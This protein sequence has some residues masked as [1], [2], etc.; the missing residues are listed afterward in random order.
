MA[1]DYWRPTQGRLENDVGRSFNARFAS[2]RTTS[3][4]FGGEDSAE[5]SLWGA[6]LRS[7]ALADFQSINRAR[8]N[9]GRYILASALGV[10]QRSPDAGFRLLLRGRDG[11]GVAEAARGYIERGPIGSV[12]RVANE[13]A[14]IEWTPL[15]VVP[16]LKFLTSAAD[17]LDRDRLEPL[18]TRLCSNFDRLSRPTAL[19]R[20]ESTLLEAPSDAQTIAAQFALDLAM[21]SEDALTLQTLRRVIYAIDWSTQPVET[22]DQWV[23]FIRSALN[24]GGDVQMVAESAFF[25]L[26]P[27]RREDLAPL[28]KVERAGAMT[29][30]VSALQTSSP[31]DLTNEEAAAAAES[32]VGALE[33]IREAA[34]QGSFSF[35]RTYDA[36]ALLVTLLL[37][38]PELPYWDEV[39]SFVS[40]PNVQRADKLD[41][42]DLL[43]TNIESVPED[44][45]DALREGFDGV[46]SRNTS[47]FLP[48]PAPGFESILLRLGSALGTMTPSAVLQDLL[49]FASSANPALR[50]Q[51]A[52]AAAH[53]EFADDAAGLS[54]VLLLSRDPVPDVRAA[55]CRA[56]LS[57]RWGRPDDENALVW[58]RV[59]EL[60]SE[61]GR[62]PTLGVLLGLFEGVETRVDAPLPI[63]SRIRTL[64]AEHPSWAVRTMAGRV[65]EGWS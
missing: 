61:G 8:Q 54:V 27:I 45:R 17:V 39:V 44:V 57:R 10:E 25:N 47:D 33:G 52:R 41:A 24:A 60:L 6:L 21:G 15:L 58:P 63:K 5:R 34:S 65:A 49:V 55:A 50:V 31:E 32:L 48:D 23:H 18:L 7:E 56:L 59:S 2:T 14:H 30:A 53:V 42:L 35:G 36:G 13:I 19:A 9:L 16:S 11:N 26:L 12:A 40:D 28:T 51:A 64:A 43:V 3:F 22:V 62:E 1:T 38:R 29:V 37:R 20:A 4:Q 46:K